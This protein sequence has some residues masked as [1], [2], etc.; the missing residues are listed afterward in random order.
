MTAVQRYCGAVRAHVARFMLCSALLHSVTHLS[1]IFKHLLRCQH[2]HELQLVFHRGECSLCHLFLSSSRWTPDPP[3]LLPPWWQALPRFGGWP[4][5][6]AGRLAQ[7][8]FSAMSI[9]GSSRDC[10]GRLGTRMRS[11]GPS[12]FGATGMRLNWLR[13]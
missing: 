4:R 6:G 13:P 5:G 12:L 9:C 11:R 8:T 1:Q 2:I 10:S 3:L 7:G